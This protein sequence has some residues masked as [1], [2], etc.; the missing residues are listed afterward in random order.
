MRKLPL[1]W[2]LMGHRGGDDVAGGG[3]DVASRVTGVGELSGAE[4]AGML[5]WR[6]MMWRVIGSSS[7]L[8]VPG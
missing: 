5:T 8:S 2:R 4:S 6:P 7:Q 3:D 1:V